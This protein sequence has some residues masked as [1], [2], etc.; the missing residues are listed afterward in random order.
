M[1]RQHHNGNIA[2][3]PGQACIHHEHRANYR[4]SALL[5]TQS[6]GPLLSHV[7][8]G[9][10]S[11]RAARTI[12]GIDTRHSPNPL[13]RCYRDSLSRWMI[14]E[15]SHRGSDGHHRIPGQR[16]SQ[17][18][19]RTSTQTPRPSAKHASDS[20]RSAASTLP[21]WTRRSDD[22]SLLLPREEAAF[23]AGV[24]WSQLTRLLT[25]LSSGASNRTNSAACEDETSAQSRTPL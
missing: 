19:P 2:N 15:H 21:A 5:P 18:P 24:R 1:W 4:A 22:A 20:G 25:G 13:R 14:R 6:P 16:D 12:G 23:D 8:P 3:D 7:R 17:T 9:R 10:G 11:P